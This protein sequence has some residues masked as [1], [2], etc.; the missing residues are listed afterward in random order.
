MNSNNLKLNL[1]KNEIMI[2]CK[3][4]EK[5]HYIPR[6]TELG[7]EP[8]PSTIP[9]SLDGQ[10]TNARATK[11]YEN[12]ALCF[13]LLISILGAVCQATNMDGQVFLFP[14]ESIL[15]YVILKQELS[16][17]L[18]SFTVCLRAFT[19]L[20]RDY[21]LLSVSSPTTD[22]AL[23]LFHWMN[24]GKSISIYVD[25]HDMR[26]WPTLNELEW[27]HIC[28]TW[29]SS[30]GVTQ[31]WLN[32][33]PLARK[34]MKRGAVIQTPLNVILGQEQDSFGG[35]FDK[36]QSFEG[37]ISDLHVWDHVLSPSDIQQVFLNNKHLNGNVI[38]WRDLPFEINGD[39]LIV[40]VQKGVC[41]DQALTVCQ[42]KI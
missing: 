39:V 34:V 13:L 33:K 31:L 36:N 2:I 7:T 26:S 19:E 37:E 14:N 8:A 18:K 9:G 12:M 5:N 17:P 24:L 22:N 1:G 20:T 25:G 27:R 38:S 11:T 35:S 23:V 16:V 30:S 41:E 3:S 29:D 21:S 15:N 32:G 10:L 28:G 40:P 6:L 42:C 4:Q